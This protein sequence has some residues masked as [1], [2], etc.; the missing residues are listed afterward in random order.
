MQATAV[1]A[2]RKH[3]AV[4]KHTLRDG[5]A[6]LADMAVDHATPSQIANNREYTAL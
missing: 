6:D 3:A 1:R 4:R 2:E 5:W